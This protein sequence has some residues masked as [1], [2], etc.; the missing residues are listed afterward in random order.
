MG[1]VSVDKNGKTWRYRF[2]IAT[3]AGKRKQISKSGFRT[4]KE[5]QAAG[6][7]ALYQYEH[8]GI[9]PDELNDKISYSDFLDVWL[10]KDVKK[11]L[12]IDT[13]AGYEKKIRLYIK[14]HLGQ[15]RI[16]SITKQNIT[17][18]LSDMYNEGFSTNT[19]Y[20]IRGIITKSFRY[21]VDNRYLIHSPAD[22]IQLKFNI[23][24]PPIK[25][26]RSN[27]HVYITKEQMDAIFNRFPVGSSS[28]IPLL[29]GYRCGLRIAEVFALT[30]EDIDFD[31]K[32]VSVN[33]QVQWQKDTER[34]EDEIK[35]SSGKKD[36]GNGYW[37]F[38]EPKYRSYRRIDIDDDLCEILLNEKIRQE[39]TKA[40]LMKT[41]SYLFSFSDHPLL[42]TNGSSPNNTPP[43]NRI[44]LTHLIDNQIE[45]TMAKDYRIQDKQ[46]INFVCR[47]SDGSY[48]TSRTMQHTSRVI[49]DKLGIK[50]F[51]FHSLRHTHGT[52]LVEAKAPFVY[53]KERLGHA[54]IEMTY[55]YI[56]HATKQFDQEGA[57]VLNGMF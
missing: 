27:P 38:C 10:E 23:G 47:R 14:P 17:E 21:A 16:K 33:R 24:A 26:T 20:S 22:G 54:K 11:H 50:D 35:A 6:N 41:D 9:A 44:Y 45:N 28:Y 29:L 12:K 56:D 15:Y 32:K 53:I 40:E 49:H 46:E 31:N 18:F 19:I 57:S 5:A 13:F 43:V 42:F 2:D 34:T 4:K 3:V 51:D 1:A 7:D 39:S 55:Q 48:V 30:W 25:A 37:Y 52:M 8:A 36:A